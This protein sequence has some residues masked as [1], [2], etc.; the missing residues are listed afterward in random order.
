MQFLP[1]T[2][3][4]RAWDGRTLAASGYPAYFTHRNENYIYPENTLTGIGS[5]VYG[6][7]LPV[8]MFNASILSDGSLGLMHDTTSTRTCTTTQTIASINQTQFRALVCDPSVQLAAGWPNENVPML[9]DVL[10]Q[11]GGRVVLWIEAVGTGAAAAAAALIA[12]YRL[13]NS[14]VISSATSTD[15]AAVAPY[16]VPWWFQTD[17]DSAAA[18]V[19]AGATGLLGSTSVTNAYITNAIAVG[20]KVA[21]WTN[22]TGSPVAVESR[23][24]AAAWRAKT[25]TNIDSSDPVY[26]A[27]AVPVQTNDT[28][29]NLRH[30]HGML[31]DYPSNS[32]FGQFFATSYTIT[33]NSA[34]NPTV[35]T[36][37]T[38]HGVVSGESITIAGNSIIPNGVYVATVTGLTTLTI[39]INPGAGSGG[40]VVPVGRSGRFGW[41]SATLSSGALMGWSCPLANAASTYHINCTVTY[42][43]VPG[44]TSRWPAIVFACMTDMPYTNSALTGVND[45]L[46]MYRASGTATLYRDDNGVSTSLA[47]DAT[48]PT[49]ASGQSRALRV[50]V[51]PTTVTVTDIASGKS[52]TKADATYRGAYWH[53][54]K[55]TTMV[56]SISGVTIS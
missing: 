45:Y 54:Y 38:T 39:P 33:S 22:M 24:N 9:E 12:R 27:A 25:A 8:V 20:L 26:T 46:F 6:D 21:I 14:C 41:S 56:A 2:S 4:D 43:T 55:N 7:A 40:T 10:N 49:V 19:T 32:D 44:D 17:T 36:T 35:I 29:A 15:G 52:V 1:V 42:D 11:F 13:Q 34:A 16:G 23:T 28:F 5:S 18:W 51:T 48:W 31:P 3:D 37:S 47:T 53:F 50:D 30:M